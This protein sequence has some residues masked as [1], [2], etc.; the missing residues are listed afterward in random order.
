M[1]HLLC[2]LLA[3]ALFSLPLTGRAADEPDIK[4][5]LKNMVEDL[6]TKGQQILEGIDEGVEAGRKKGETVDGAKI[7]ANKQEL[8]TMLKLSSQKVESVGNETF[9]VTLALRN[10]NDFPVRVT[11]LGQSASVVLLDTEGFSYVLSDPRVQGQD[12]TV[13]AR[14]ATRVRYTFARVEGKPGVLR[15]LGQDIPLR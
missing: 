5:G 7:V 1:R 4:E 15:L 14:S 10:D 6:V 11:G 9:E 3:C 8:T 13:L 12:V 2:T